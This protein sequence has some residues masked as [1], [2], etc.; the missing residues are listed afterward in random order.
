MKQK[1]W[2]RDNNNV[3]DISI[4]R[5]FL[6]LLQKQEGWKGEIKEN[7]LDDSITLVCGSIMSL[8]EFLSHKDHSA[9]EYEE[10]E[11]LILDI[12]L[13]SMVL[14]TYKKGIFF[15]NLD[16]ILVIDRKFFLLR[17]LTHV[18]DITKI[19]KLLLSY[20]MKI[21]K[22]DER[23][24]APE[25]KKRLESKVLPFYTSITVGYYSLAKICIRC[26]DL[27]DGLGPIKGSKMYFFL[28]RCL[29][30]EGKRYF[31]YI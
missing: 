23:F 9:M 29:A 6:S 5:D 4:Y 12:G 19:D 10:V 14:G 13:Q 3:N 1:T 31:L 30:E 2:S 21:K 25:L 26:L 24:I 18:L 8:E 7:P 28:E 11:K 27:S 16:D 20:P 15:L 22:S 17:D